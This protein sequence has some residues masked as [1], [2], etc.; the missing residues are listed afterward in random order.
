MSYLVVHPSEVA[1]WQR[2]FTRAGMTLTFQCDEEQ[3]LTGEVFHRFEINV[4]GRAENRASRRAVRRNAY[5]A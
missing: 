5:A 2:L 1:A 3:P 4:V